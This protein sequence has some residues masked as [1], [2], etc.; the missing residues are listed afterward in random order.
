VSENASIRFEE[1]IPESHAYFSLFESTGWNKS[2]HANTTELHTSISN[3]WYTL[4][5]Y[6]D[7]N[8]LVGF[9]RI[10]S[11]GVLYAFVCDMIVAP[12]YQNQGIGSDI[13]KRLV[14]RCKAEGLRVIWL[15][16]ASN[17][18][19]F[20]KK[21]GFDERPSDAPGMQLNLHDMC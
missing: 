14:T 11:D 6:N 7:E 16:A 9:G 15:F 10:V 20:Y 1:G 3:S 2:Y 18:S 21:H 13:L 5:V 4:C 19:G 17:R 12:A 8:E